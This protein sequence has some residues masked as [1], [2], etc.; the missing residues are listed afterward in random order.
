MVLVLL[1]GACGS[2]SG[3]ARGSGP[4]LDHAQFIAEVEKNCAKRKANSATMDGKGALTGNER[5]KA[6]EEF[7]QENAKL[8]DELLALPPAD[9][10]DRAFLD[11]L[12]EF[13]DEIRS[14]SAADPDSSEKSQEIGKEA[15]ELI[16]AQGD[17]FTCLDDL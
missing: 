8:V 14:L 4:E 10:K 12:R 15:Q 6:I 1:L 16:R 11:S 5:S 2:G 13:W 17:E 3:S 7:A 9:V